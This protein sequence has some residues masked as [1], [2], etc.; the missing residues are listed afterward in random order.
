MRILLPAAIAAILF[1]CGSKAEPAARVESPVTAPTPVAPGPTTPTPTAKWTKPYP[2]TRRDNVVETI[3]GVQVA[4][5]YRWLEDASKPEVQAWMKAQDDYARAELAKLPGR[6]ALVKR[7]KELYYYDALGAPLH[8]KGRYFW[9]RKHA[10]K[11]KSVVYWKQG[12]KGTEKILFDP[13]TWSTDGSVSLGDWWPSWNGKLVAYTVKPNNADE[14]DMHVVEVATGK[15]LGDV[16]TGAKYATA[17]WTPDGKGFYY[18]WLPPVGGDITVANR[19]GY[20]ELRFHALGTDPTKDPVVHEATHDPELALDGEVSKDGRWLVAWLS[21]GWR[22]TD[23]YFRDL[24]AKQKAWT[25]LV[26]GVDATFGVEVWKNRF[27]VTTNMDAPRYRVYVVDP[28][29]PARSAWKELVAQDAEA[30]LDKV[31]LVGGHLVLT[32]MRKATSEIEVHTLAGKLVRKIDL[33][34]KGTTGEMSGLPDEDT[35]YVKY[36]SFTEPSIIFRT[37]IKRAKAREWSRVKIPIDT[38]PYVTDQ[39]TYASKDGTPVTMFVIHRKDIK[40]GAKTPTILYGYGGF[41]VNMSPWFSSATMAWVERGGVYAVPNLRGGGEY[42]EEWHRAGMLDKKQNVFDDVIAAAR[43]LIDNGWTDA[44]H[45]AIHGGS[46]GGLLVGAAMT[47]APELFGAV[48]CEVPLLDM[49]RFHKFGGGMTWVPEYGSA[50]SPEQF[51]ALYA[52]SPYHHVKDGVAY[53]A[54]L[55]MSADA[56]DRVD[57]MHARKFTAAIQ[58]ATTSDAPVLLR[59]ER[60]SGHGGADLVKQAIE[61]TAD[62]QLLLAQQLSDHK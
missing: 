23:V 40:P 8:R 26:E 62:M 53:P 2:E 31:N 12:E 10:D 17:S 22:S 11:E 56:D 6:E 61:K 19:P 18:T 57:P 32:Y 24:E 50:E 9:S 43:W 27:Y 15:E 35:G 7:L 39:V 48:I 49:V 33:P 52:Y 21:H 4:D 14:A 34:G 5:P 38:S 1:A 42:G 54:L 29:K 37:S 13:N 30:T 47:Q 36:T 28:R 16:I 60:H 55:M 58:R 25:P 44:K 46:N 3:H 45:L 41:N 20:A 59:I 51:R